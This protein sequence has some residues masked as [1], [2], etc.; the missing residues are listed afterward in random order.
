MDFTKRAMKEFIYVA[1]EGF[2]TESKLLHWIE[3]GLEH[4]KSKL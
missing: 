2:K 1:S 3:L 4:A